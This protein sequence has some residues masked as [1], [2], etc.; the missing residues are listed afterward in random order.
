MRKA[1][2]MILSMLAAG[3]ASTPG[4]RGEPTEWRRVMGNE[5]VITYI[6]PNTI[7]RS[8]DSVSMWILLDR[9]TAAVSHGKAYLSEK[10]QEEF[11]CK[12]ERNRTLYATR[13]SGNMGADDV[14]FKDGDPGK[15]MPIPPGSVIEVLWKVACGLL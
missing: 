12:E 7:R 5:A 13:H 10:T 4:N 11:D 6:E 9:K 3:C 1:T 14:V 2:L 15:W 8:G